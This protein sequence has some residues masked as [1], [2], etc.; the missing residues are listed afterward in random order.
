MT[1]LKRDHAPNAVHGGAATMTYG[2]CTLTYWRTWWRCVGLV[3][4][5]PVHRSMLRPQGQR[6]RIASL[7]TPALPPHISRTT[8]RPS[9]CASCQNV[10][11][12]TSSSLKSQGFHGWG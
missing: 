2:W 4:S 5:I 6:R 7:V 12:E 11:G 8:M 3:K 10:E 1:E 9:V